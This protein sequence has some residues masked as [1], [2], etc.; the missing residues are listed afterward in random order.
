MKVTIISVDSEK[1]VNSDELELLGRGF[2]LVAPVWGSG[3]LSVEK[4]KPIFRAE[5]EIRYL[6][7]PFFLAAH[8]AFSCISYET[9]EGACS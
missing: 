1:G 2:I 6:H 5:S 8:L 3:A 4:K 7:T 9:Y